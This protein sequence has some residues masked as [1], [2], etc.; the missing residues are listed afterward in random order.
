MPAKLKF[1]LF[2]NVYALL[3]DFLA[4]AAFF[5]AWSIYGKYLVLGLISAL[6]GALSL[7]AAIGIHGTYSEKC[8]IYTALLRKNTRA[9]RPESFREFVSVPCHRVLVRM[10]LRK[11]GRSGDYAAILK[12]YYRYPWQRKISLETE[13]KVFKTKEEGDAW[14]L[15]MRRKTF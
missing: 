3:M 10:V 5:F 4:F 6:V 8:R 7:Y 9:F 12:A 15:Q 11:L 1:W 2:V 13:F 14:L